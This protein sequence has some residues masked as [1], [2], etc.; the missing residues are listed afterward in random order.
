MDTKVK[1]ELESRVK[2]I[3][4]FIASKGIG[5]SKLSKAR[6]VQRNVNLGVLLGSLFT[7]AGVVAWL[8]KGGDEAE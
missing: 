6:K 1:E 7:V 5:S 8:L 2:K 3:E 4:D